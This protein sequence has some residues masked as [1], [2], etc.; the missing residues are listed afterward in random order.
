MYVS[1]SSDMAREMPPIGYQHALLVAISDLGLQESFGRLKHKIVFTWELAAVDSSGT[2]FQISKIVNLSLNEEAGLRHDI[3]GWL[4]RPLTKEED[5]KLDLDWYIGHEAEL[6]LEIE[7][8][9]NGRTGAIYRGIKPPAAL[10]GMRPSGQPL[11]P[12]IAEMA[13]KGEF[14]IPE[15][16][17]N[18]PA[19][20]GSGTPAAPIPAPAVPASSAVPEPSAPGPATKKPGSLTPEH[21]SAMLAEI[22][23]RKVNMKNFLTYCR[24]QCIQDIPDKRFYGIMAV[25][26]KKPLRKKPREPGED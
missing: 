17:K 5:E 13:Q 15:F 24:V 22:Q 25:L 11:P 6:F 18:E 20:V 12:W 2:P 3:E 21:V 8:R 9:R 14:P 10:R 26:V 19:T 23:A 16:M 7:N 1:K 4:G